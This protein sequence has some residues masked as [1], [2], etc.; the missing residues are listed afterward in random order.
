MWLFVFVVRSEM[1]PKPETGWPW[2]ISC[3]WM[4]RC[5]SDTC[6]T[7]LDN[8][9]SRS[10]FSHPHYLSDG[11]FFPLIFAHLF[12][13]IKF[14]LFRAIAIMS[15]KKKWGKVERKSADQRSWKCAMEWQTADCVDKINSRWRLGFVYLCVSPSRLNATT[16]TTMWL[17]QWTA[18]IVSA[19]RSEQAN[20]R[21]RKWWQCTSNSN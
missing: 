10:H 15:E 20:E 1:N 6:R 5:A 9:N 13:I 7:F 21:R 3:G 2:H 19:I 12:F 18:K 4:S 17:I 11:I 8:V 14:N 16:C